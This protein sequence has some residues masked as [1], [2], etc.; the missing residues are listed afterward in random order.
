MKHKSEAKL[1]ISIILKKNDKRLN[2]LEK[3]N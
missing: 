2:L 1:I 3:V